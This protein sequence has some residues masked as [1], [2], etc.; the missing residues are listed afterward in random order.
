MLTLSSPSAAAT[1]ASI[2]AQLAPYLGVSA[3]PAYPSSPAPAPAV[4]PPVAVEQQRFRAIW[5]YA[6]A[7]SDELSFAADDVLLVP[8][9]GA[10]KGDEWW[11][12]ALERAPHVQG[13][14]PST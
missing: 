14:F 10:Q 3:T 8:A 2:Q 6:A 1:A 11:L 9:A 13:L 12:G 7:A 4:Q 5:A